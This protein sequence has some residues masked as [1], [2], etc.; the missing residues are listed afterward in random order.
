MVAVRVARALL[1]GVLGYGTGRGI[2]TVALKIGTNTRA[3][4]GSVVYSDSTIGDDPQTGYG[5][6]IREEKLIGDRS[7]ARH[8]STIDHG[9]RIGDTVKVHRNVHVT[10]L[11]ALEDGV[12]LAPGLPVGNHLRSGCP[13]CHICPSVS[14]ILG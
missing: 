3:R 13:E 10:R 8:N 14:A 1:A 4:A 12:F 5:G 2:E 7:S 9:S 6:A 11:R